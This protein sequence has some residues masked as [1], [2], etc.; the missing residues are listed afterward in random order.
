MHQQ[1]WKEHTPGMI[2]F[3]P[4][5]HAVDYLRDVLSGGEG[6]DISVQRRDSKV[7]LGMYL[8]TPLVSLKRVTKARRERVG[9]EGLVL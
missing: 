2:R 7:P 5:D 4:H 8:V 1:D 6:K 3:G 9:R